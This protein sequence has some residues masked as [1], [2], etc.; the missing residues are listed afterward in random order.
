MWRGG[1][2]ASKWMNDAR[3]MREDAASY[4]AA[5][6]P[7]E[8]LWRIVEDASA[9]ASER[10]GAALALRHGIDDAGRTRLRLAAEACA[11]NRLRV[12]LE[13]ATLDD[14][15]ALEHALEPLHA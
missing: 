2:S 6:L 12:A 10:V 1:R 15:E 7:D 11:E 8:E 13:T 9:S 5:V 4:R 3:K 14:D